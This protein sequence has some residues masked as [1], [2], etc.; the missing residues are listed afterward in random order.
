MKVNERP[1][2]AAEAVVA[3]LSQVTSQNEDFPTAFFTTKT[4][5]SS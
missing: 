1:R 2:E 5:D 4:L 3:D